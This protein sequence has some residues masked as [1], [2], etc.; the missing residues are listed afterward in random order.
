MCYFVV[1]QSASIPT[2]YFYCYIY[3]ITFWKCELWLAKS[4][5]SINCMENMERFTPLYAIAYAIVNG[6]ENLRFD[7]GYFYVFVFYTLFYKRNRKHFPRVPI[8]YRNTPGSLGELEITWKHSPYGHGRIKGG[9][10][11][12]VPGAPRFLGPRRFFGPRGCLWPHVFR[13]RTA[14]FWADISYM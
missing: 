8:R 13:D 14:R 1:F 2:E 12:Q 5:V 3:K 6:M 9:H 10:F 11:G 7:K 4:R